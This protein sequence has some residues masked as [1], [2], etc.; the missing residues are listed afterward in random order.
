MSNARGNPGKKRYNSQPLEGASKDARNDVSEMDSDAL[1][2]NNLPT[3][4]QVAERGQAQG[5]TGGSMS[6]TTSN[7]F[8]PLAQSNS[9][10]D[11]S[12][13]SASVTS[14]GSRRGSKIGIEPNR[15]ATANPDGVGTDLTYSESS[16]GAASVFFTPKPDG[17]YR[18]DFAIEFQQLN[19]R[20]FKGS[21]T[22][23]EARDVV[24]RDTLGFNPNLLHS[25]RP[26][27]GG[28]PTIRFKLK[29]QINMDNLSG[30]EYFEL[31]RKVNKD[32][33]DS[34]SCRI[35][36]I[37][38]LQAAPNYDGTSNDVRWLKIENWEY[39][40]EGE[41]IM[42]WLRLYGEPLSLLGED[43]L[44]DSDSDAGPLGNGTY[45]VKMKLSRDVPQFLP[46]HG[47]KIRV[48]FKNMNKLCTNC[49][50]AHSRRQCTNER[51]PW[52]IYVRDF[53]M[54][55]PEVP[56]SFYGKWWEVIDK[57]FPGYF[58][59]QEDQVENI[60]QTAS[61][62]MQHETSLLN[63]EQSA[64]HNNPSDINERSTGPRTVPTRPPDRIQDSRQLSRDPRLNRQNEKS[65]EINELMMRGLTINEANN[66][67]KN[68]R[69]QE[70][71]EQMMQ[72]KGPDR[73]TPRG[74]SQHKHSTRNSTTIIGPGTSRGRGGLS[75]N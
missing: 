28:I 31:E 42:E 63:Q 6:F 14:R 38:G 15:G 12:M 61:F 13:R 65:D 50:G 4:S 34:I 68:K 45:S 54:N 30:V 73:Q 59:D 57:E 66:Y 74:R 64:T 18:D 8:G 48:Y 17:A 21:I 52:I 60:R 11:K 40:G 37:R 35:M 58:E 53:M 43:V 27:F 32:R 19:G 20:P 69:E 33:T 47:R 2:E 67:V 7:R 36:G 39:A 9:Y 71:L 22:L 44:P 62:L 26:I 51:V 24:F 72:N 55:N 56:E 75:F 70:Q 3:W 25:I 5:T 41:R 29:E 1:R 10:P 49:Y 46:M 16:L 23:K